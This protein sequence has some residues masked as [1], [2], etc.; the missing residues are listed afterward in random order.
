MTAI[1]GKGAVLQMSD[2]TLTAFT[3]VT[4]IRS[5][6]FPQLQGDRIDVTTHGSPGFTRQYISGLDDIPAA[7]FAINWLPADASQ[8]ETTGLLAVQR[9]KA[10]RVFKVTLPTAVSPTKVFTFSAQILQF[11]PTVPIDNA[12]Q[13]EIQLQPTAAPTIGSA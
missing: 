8:D 11:N 4:E 1:L 13:A 9:S 5:V 12:M 3:T 7:T 10:T 6:P 2:S